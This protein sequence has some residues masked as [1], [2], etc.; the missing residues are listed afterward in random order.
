MSM[1]MAVVVGSIILCVG[2]ARDEIPQEIEEAMQDVTTAY[3]S[4]FQVAGK[5]RESLVAKISSISCPEVKLSC[6]RRYI[7]RILCLDP[8]SIDLRYRGRYLGDVVQHVILTADVLVLTGSS[9]EEA[10]DARFKLLSYVRKHMQRLHENVQTMPKGEEGGVVRD[11]GAHRAYLEA[12][13]GYNAATCWYEQYVFK[14]EKHDFLFDIKDLPEDVKERLRKKFEDFL[15]RP[16]RPPEQC[17]R[18]HKN[19]AATESSSISHSLRQ[20]F[21]HMVVREIR[22]IEAPKHLEYVVEVDI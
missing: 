9:K 17:I 14:V 3:T 13:T 18:D 10:W 21:R 11:V 8:E 16:M 6:Y 1:K 2:C 7:R 15:G 22:E 12:K 4:N 5:K 20:E 19:H